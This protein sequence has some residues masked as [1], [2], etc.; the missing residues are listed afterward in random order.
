MEIIFV[1]CVFWFFVV[2]IIG[3]F[4]ANVS[5]I[6]SFL[7]T[8]LLVLCAISIL[9]KTTPEEVALKAEI[10]KQQD[11]LAKTKYK[12]RHIVVET[13][14]QAKKIITE[15]ENGIDFAKLANKYSIFDQ[16]YPK[17]GDLG[18]VVASELNQVISKAIINLQ[19]GK[20]TKTPI[21]TSSGWEIFLREKTH[22]KK[23][24]GEYKIINNN[25]VY[26]DVVNDIHTK[27][28]W[29]RCSLGQNWNG[30]TCIGDLKLF[31]LQEVKKQ[32]NIINKNNYMGYKDWR[33]PTLDELKGLVYCDKGFLKEI[34]GVGFN[35][36]FS[37]VSNDQRIPRILDFDESSGHITF[38]E[39][40]S[41]DFI[42]PTINQEIFPNT[43]GVPFWSST[44]FV[45]LDTGEPT[46]DIK[47]AINF[48]D[49]SDAF[50]GINAL[51]N[52]AAIRFVRNDKKKLKIR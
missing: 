32:L 30:S 23:Q 39:I 16:Y 40:N 42:R 13:E 34:Y 26:D 25:F 45:R 4:K 18:W 35:D 28:M 2:K 51:N 46:D 14:I 6:S 41:V 11:E 24:D 20:F 36:S 37:C 21:L 43:P 1:F 52:S 33:L 50:V 5:L 31:D 15:L 3:F 8:V 47:V 27:L 7:V 9:P 12:L 49:G 38:E 44:S 10:A 19:D 48:N 29:M 22:Q 17:G